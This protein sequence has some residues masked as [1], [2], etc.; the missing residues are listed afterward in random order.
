MVAPNIIITN[1]CSLRNRKPEFYGDTQYVKK[2]KLHLE[3]SNWFVYRSFYRTWNICIL[4]LQDASRFICYATSSMVYKHFSVWLIYD[5]GFD[6]VDYYKANH[7]EKMQA[8]IILLKVL[9]D[10]CRKRGVY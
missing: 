3:Y 4:G 8:E 7:S 1:I 6:S 5:F 2:I 10:K 9:K